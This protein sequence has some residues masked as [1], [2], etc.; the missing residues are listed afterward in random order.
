MMRGM[1]AS[2]ILLIVAVAAVL[3]IVAARVLSVW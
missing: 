3:V 1:S 2:R